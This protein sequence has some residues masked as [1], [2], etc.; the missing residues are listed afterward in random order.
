[1]VENQVISMLKNSR[2]P[3]KAAVESIENGWWGIMFFIILMELCL[4]GLVCEFRN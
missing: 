4:V 1:M 2:K 3:Q